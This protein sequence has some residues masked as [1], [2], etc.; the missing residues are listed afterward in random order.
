MGE[1]LDALLTQEEMAARLK[2]TVRTVVRLQKE[3]VLPRIELGKAV[4]FYW[5][6]VIS[7]LVTNFTVTKGVPVA[8]PR[9]IEPITNFH[10]QQ[11]N[12]Q[13]GTQATARPT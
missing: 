8:A 13:P 6:S 1:G 7:H 10:G 4:R 3:G 12:K 9:A 2:T 11:T 5:P